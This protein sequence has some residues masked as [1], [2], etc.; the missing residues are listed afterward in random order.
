MVIPFLVT[1]QDGFKAKQKERSDMQRLAVCEK[2][3]GC[4]YSFHS[5]I[6]NT[7]ISNFRH[8]YDTCATYVWAKRRFM[9]EVGNECV[10]YHAMK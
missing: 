7:F 3:H 10:H 9:P 4:L 1:L 8:K 6:M 5:M 2:Q